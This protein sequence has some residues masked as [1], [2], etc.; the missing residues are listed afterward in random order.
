MKQTGFT[1]RVLAGIGALATLG[2]ASTLSAQA[3]S[4][5]SFQPPRVVERDFNFG[6][7]DAGSAGTS[8]VFQWR[9]G[10][11]PRTQLS[12]DVGLADPDGRNSNNYFLFGGQY[13]YQISQSRPDVPLDFLFTGGLFAAFG[14]GSNLIRIPAGVSIGHRFPLD[15]GFA[16]TPYIHPRISIDFCNECGPDGDSDSELGIDFD[17]GATFELTRQLAIR[18]SATFG[19]SDI[20][21]RNNDGFGVSFSWAP[22]V[23]N[24]SVVR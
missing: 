19:G 1:T 2:G 9:E 17:L 5:P 15:Q 13:A 22:P 7:A 23:L 6:V 3:W 24:R 8:I 21:Y 11:A 16:I 18:A 4:Y 10:V 14:G 12:L 20:S